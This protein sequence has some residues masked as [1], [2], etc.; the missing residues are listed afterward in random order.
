MR[1]ERLEVSGSTRYMPEPLRAPRAGGLCFA[2][3][4]SYL[5]RLTSY[6]S[7]L[8]SHRISV[9]HHTIGNHV[10]ERVDRPAVDMYF[11]VQVW[12]SRQSGIPHQGDVLAPG[13][14]LAGLYQDLG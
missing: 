4:T 2:L 14:P 5:L 11:I 12:T 6:L 10:L 7:R 3:H 8:T 13:D 1:R 9:R